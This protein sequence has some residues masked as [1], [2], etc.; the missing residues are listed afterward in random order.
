MM[1]LKQ[2]Y[3]CVSAKPLVLRAGIGNEQLSLHFDPMTLIFSGPEERF[4]P[5]SSGFLRLLS[6]VLQAYR[7]GL[8][9]ASMRQV[10]VEWANSLTLCRFRSLT[11]MT[12]GDVYF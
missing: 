6:S 12:R 7:S 8:G 3:L 2:L 1:S 11:L 4:L 5:F 9:M 10:R